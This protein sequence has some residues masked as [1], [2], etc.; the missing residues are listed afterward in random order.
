MTATYS[1]HVTFITEKMSNPRTQQTGFPHVACL[2]EYAGEGGSK[3]RR[4]EW[5]GFGPGAG[6]GFL[7]DSDRTSWIDDYIRFPTT[8]KALDQARRMMFTDYGPYGGQ[9]QEGIRYRRNYVYPFTDCISL[10]YDVARICGFPVAPGALVAPTQLIWRL[11]DNYDNYTH[12]N[13]LPY[14]WTV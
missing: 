2:F 8:N 5:F 3:R 9:R 10:G 4:L 14:P 12:Y 6:G 13:E 7:D 11:R 1:A